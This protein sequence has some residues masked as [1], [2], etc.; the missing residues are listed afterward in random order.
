[1]LGGLEPDI[2]SGQLRAH[3]RT[4]SPPDLVT[5]A[6][7]YDDL[8]LSSHYRPLCLDGLGLEDGFRQAAKSTNSF[9]LVVG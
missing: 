1:M 4:L 7:L 3:R 2:A 8:P 6:A 5:L 9:A